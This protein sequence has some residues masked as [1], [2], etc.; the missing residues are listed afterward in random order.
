MDEVSRVILTMRASVRRPFSRF[1]YTLTEQFS[2]HARRKGGSQKVSQGRECHQS[3]VIRSS[4]FTLFL[5]SA[6]TMRIMT[7][8]TSVVYFSVT[9]ITD[10]FSIPWLDSQVVSHQPPKLG[11]EI[12]LA[13]SYRF[14]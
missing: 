1:A 3:S 10:L 5:N 6:V 7:L 9:P 12:C 2:T 14:L 11:L 4:T 13:S 8:E